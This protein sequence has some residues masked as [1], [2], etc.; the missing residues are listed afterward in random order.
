M[1]WTRLSLLMNVTRVPAGTVSV[2]GETPDAVMVIVVPPLASVWASAWVLASALASASASASELEL[3]LGLELESA[4]ASESV[5]AR[6]TGS[7]SFRRYLRRRLRSSEDT[8]PP[9]PPE[10]RTRD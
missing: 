2:F 7:A 8:R 1:S 10:D 6:A 4:W 9:W 5:S 3:E